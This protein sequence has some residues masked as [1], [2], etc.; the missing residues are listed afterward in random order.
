STPAPAQSFPAHARSGSTPAPAA[1]GL[2]AAPLPRSPAPPRSPPSP[3]SAPVDRPLASTTEQRPHPVLLR[4]LL[5]RRLH[6]RHQ[7]PSLPQNLERP[8]LCLVTHGVKHHIRVVHDLI[9]IDRV[10]INRLVRPQLTHVI[11][12]LYRCRPDHPRSLPRRKLHRKPTHTPRR[13][14]DQNRLVLLEVCRVK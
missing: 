10:I 6:N 3:Q 4:L 8:L 9:E 12:I 5:R 2:A 14:M 11:K 13:G 7:N 1:P